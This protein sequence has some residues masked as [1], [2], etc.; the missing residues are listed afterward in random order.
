MSAMTRTSMAAL[1]VALAFLFLLE[2]AATAGTAVGEPVRRLRQARSLLRRLNKAPLASIEMRP[3]YHTGSLYNDS[4]NAAPHPITQTWHQNG[5]CPENTVPIRRNKE[6][7][8]LRASSVRKY[9]KKSPGSIP[10]ANL[11]SSVGDP[12][13][14]NVL[15]GHQHAVAHAQG[16]DKY[17]GTRAGFNLWQP[18]IDRANDFSL[19]QLWITNGSYSG[20]DLN[21]IEVG[22]QV[23]PYLYN[24]S[25][26]RLF[27]YWTR[28][29]YKKTGCYNLLCSGFIQTSNQIA[30]GG[31]LSPVSIYGASQYYIDIFVWKDPKGGNWWLQV[32][33][34]DLG[35]WPSSIFSNLADGASSVQWGGEVF[36]PDAGQTSTP[37]G[38]GHF[39]EEGF[40][41]ASHIKNINVVDS[42]NSLRMPSG[43][44][45]QNKQRNCYNVQNGT[46]N[47]WG[48]YIYYGGPGK[49]PNCP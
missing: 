14:P 24:D 46:N 3:S 43:V 42:S 27:I 7:D 4:N 18:K 12:D 13:T 44:D 20:N 1:V 8:V 32:G 9:G 48:T 39:P 33:G 16:A 36:S 6:E 34:Y 47:D 2:G 31:S 26:T 40:G 21:T 15:R 49:N 19:T 38:S 35:Y 11:I 22:W 10:I 37:M 17:Y 41:K 29:A 28:D 45:L 30:I 25:N 5:K 23:F